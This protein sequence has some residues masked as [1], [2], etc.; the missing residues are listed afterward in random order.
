M[1]Y[2]SRIIPCATAVHGH[3][4]HAQRMQAQVEVGKRMIDRRQ[5]RQILEVLQLA[6][7]KRACDRHVV[8]L[9]RRPKPSPDA[10]LGPALEQDGARLSLAGLGDQ[11]H[12][13]P[14]RAQPFALLARQFLLSSVARAMQSVRIGQRVQAG[15]VRVQTVAPKSMMACV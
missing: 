5:R 15:R 8:E 12:R 9:R 13:L 3:A 6:L 7:A 11:Q 10:G 2:Q 14:R 4:A 1:R